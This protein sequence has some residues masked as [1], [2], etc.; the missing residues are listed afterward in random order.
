MAKLPDTPNLDW[1]RKRAKR[2]LRELRKTLPDAQ[3]AQAQFDLARDFGFS[4]WRN[5]K[6][7]ADALTWTAN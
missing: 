6:A 1:L 7:H 3:L 5:L 2:R 4:S